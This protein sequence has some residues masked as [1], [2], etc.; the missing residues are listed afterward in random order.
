MTSGRE[1]TIRAAAELAAGDE[2]EAWHNRRL[3]HQGTVL[4]VLP[5]LGLFWIRDGQTGTRRLLD[6]EALDVVRVGAGQQAGTGQ[7]LG[8]R[9]RTGS[10]GE[11]PG[12]AA[13]MLWFSSSG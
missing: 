9:K 12:A 8:A 3:F 10:G 13:D 11:A 7:K 4:R 5:S 2:I 6:V 1:R